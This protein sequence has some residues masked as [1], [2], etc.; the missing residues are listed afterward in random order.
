LSAPPSAD[1]RRSGERCRRFIR[2][3]NASYPRT[4]RTSRPLCPPAL[5]CDSTELYAP[6]LKAVRS[7]CGASVVPSRETREPKVCRLSAGGRRIRNSSTAPNQQRLASSEMSLIDCRQC[8]QSSRNLCPR[9]ACPARSAGPPL[10]PARRT[11]PPRLATA[12]SQ[13]SSKLS[14]LPSRHCRSTRTS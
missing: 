6:L 4:H 11:A 13:Y 3:P 8:D 14:K 1:R 9:F 7:K 2:Q 10:G 12:I 5:G